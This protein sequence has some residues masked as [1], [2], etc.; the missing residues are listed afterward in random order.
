MVLSAQ[1]EHRRDPESPTRWPRSIH[2]GKHPGSQACR[3]KY[4]TCLCKTRF[5]LGSQDPSRIPPS[6]REA[7]RQEYK[8]AFLHIIDSYYG[9]GST[10]ILL[11][12]KLTTVCQFT[13][14]RAAAPQLLPS[15]TMVLPKRNTS[16]LRRTT[17]SHTYWLVAFLATSAYFMIKLLTKMMSRSL[18]EIGTHTKLPLPVFL[19]IPKTG[20]TAIEGLLALANHKKKSVPFFTHL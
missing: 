17:C 9:A 2:V 3:N 10:A 14:H 1:Q 6:R 19:H 7:S 20:G 16:Y 8:I 5:L 15:W 11:H 13:D 4:N 18:D 12:N